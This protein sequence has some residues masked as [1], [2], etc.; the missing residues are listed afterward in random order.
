MEQEP[1]Q[2]LL[3][4]NRKETFSE[5]SLTIEHSHTRPMVW[6]FLVGGI[7][8]ILPAILVLLASNVHLAMLTV[9]IAMGLGL[10]AGR[11]FTKRFSFRLEACTRDLCLD[12]K[13]VRHAW[14]IDDSWELSTDSRTVEFNT[15]PMHIT[16]A[17]YVGRFTVATLTSPKNKIEIILKQGEPEDTIPFACKV[18]R[19]LKPVD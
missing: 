10:L 18:E 13:N 15:G 3:P 2:V 4:L 17:D 1:V 14:K 8:S 19:L 6:G 7:V 16:S 12:I 5:G 11:L 9:L